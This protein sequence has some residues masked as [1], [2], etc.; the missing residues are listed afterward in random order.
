MI[1]L[2]RR[3]KDVRAIATDSE[4]AMLTGKMEGHRSAQKTGREK[5]YLRYKESNL[6]LPSFGAS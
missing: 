2:L 6:D 3:R 1:L 5:D 4:F